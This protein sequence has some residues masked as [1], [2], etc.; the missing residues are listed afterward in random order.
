MINQQ[1][2]DLQRLEDK[3]ILN[4]QIHSN[5]FFTDNKLVDN[6]VR[7]NFFKQNF[8][9]AYRTEFTRLI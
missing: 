1:R 5:F 3:E 2:K 4:D 8:L 7:T 6:F 9:H